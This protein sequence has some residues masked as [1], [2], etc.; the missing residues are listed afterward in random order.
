MTTPVAG[1]SILKSL[2][3]TPPAF[4][5]AF[6]VNELSLL[7]ESATTELWELLVIA[8]AET[9]P[10]TLPELVRRY[11]EVHDLPQERLVRGL[12]GART[13]LRGA[14]KHNV[15]FDDFSADIETLCGAS[16]SDVQAFLMP[17]YHDA[18]TLLRHEVKY[19]A[20]TDHGQLLTRVD[21]RVDVMKV[22][23]R[24]VEIEEPVVL[25]TMHL[26]EGTQTRRVTF[27]ALPDMLQQLQSMCGTILGGSSAARD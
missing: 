9:S 3:G 10:P 26:V 8:F 11:A 24:G 6:D 4:D 14:A 7:S 23:Q 16:A 1:D 15:A 18:M 20:L 27:Q 13:L 2:G 19:A 17:R 21:W 22:A 5:L 12:R 25:V